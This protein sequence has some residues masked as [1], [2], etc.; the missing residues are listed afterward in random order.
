MVAKLT[1]CGLVRDVAEL[2]QLKVKE[3]A[4]L[5]GVDASAAQFFFRR[6]YGEYQARRVAVVMRLEHSAGGRG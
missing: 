2:Y 1:A 3:L 4:A 5:P 6:A